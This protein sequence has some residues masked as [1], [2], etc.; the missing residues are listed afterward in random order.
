MI[1]H[2]LSFC[3]NPPPAAN[4]RRPLCLRWR[5]R[6][7][8]SRTSSDP[9]S[10]AAVPL[11]L[12]RS[13]RVSLTGTGIWNVPSLDALKGDLS[14]QNF[15]QLFWTTLNEAFGRANQQSMCVSVVASPGWDYES[16]IGSLPQW[17]QED[18]DKADRILWRRTPDDA[19][20]QLSHEN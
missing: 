7:P 8:C 19:A 12:N 10:L 20:G 15:E 5:G 4:S 1:A 16:G 2:F 9:R 14:G 3:P 11:V 6:V 18:I 13:G 17:T